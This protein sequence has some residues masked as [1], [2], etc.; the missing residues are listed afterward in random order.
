MTL[1]LECAEQLSWLERHCVGRVDSAQG[2]TRLTHPEPGRLSSHGHVAGVVDPG[3]SQIVKLEVVGL[4]RTAG[5][6]VAD[7][8]TGRRD[9][10]HILPGAD[11]APA[12]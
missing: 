8:F 7:W 11:Y 10:S 2:S 9:L 6:L 3:Y 12:G 5:K 1:K 4:R